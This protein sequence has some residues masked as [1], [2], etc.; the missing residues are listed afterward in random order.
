MAHSRRVVEVVI[1]HVNDVVTTAQLMR[2][3]SL[4]SKVKFL[5]NTLMLD[6]DLGTYFERTALEV[7]FGII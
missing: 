3:I 5:L 7:I 4:L 1:V 6:P 2:Q